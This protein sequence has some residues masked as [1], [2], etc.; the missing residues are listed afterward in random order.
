MTPNADI[1]RKLLIDLELGSSA[2]PTAWPV[3]VAFL[4]NEID[5]VISCYDTAGTSDG[6]LMK[7][8][9]RIEHPGVQIRVRS[10]K[11]LGGWQK[12]QTIAEALDAQKNTIVTVG[13]DSFTLKNIS[14]TGAILPMGVDPED[15]RKRFN[16][17]VNAILT[18]SINE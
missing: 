14:R 3:Y 18:V 5:N 13:S 16:F 9:K 15:D 7:D 4:P 6:R 1:I 11:Y 17:T 2:P 12:V 10:L 8:G